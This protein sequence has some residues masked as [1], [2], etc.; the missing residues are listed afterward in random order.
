MIDGRP[1]GICD[2]CVTVAAA[3]RTS[4]EVAE[5]RRSSICTPAYTSIHRLF[6]SYTVYC[7]LVEYWPPC[8]RR[9]HM[10][11]TLRLISPKNFPPFLTGF[12]YSESYILWC[13]SI[14]CPYDN[15][16]SQDPP[17]A[18]LIGEKGHSTTLPRAVYTAVKF[19]V[20]SRVCLAIRSLTR[21]A[22]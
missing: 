18:N 10:H 21:S 14:I 22:S 5:T 1:S 8:S 11:A 4:Q 20:G 17:L 3:R 2:C 15:P 9:L 12:P 6:Y 13:G 19:N 16:C 7:V